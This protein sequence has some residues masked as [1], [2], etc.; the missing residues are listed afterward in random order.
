M[1]DPYETLGI[2]KNAT[3]DEVKAAYRALAKK[4]H[5]DN[6][7]GDPNA[8]ELAE[9]K[10]KVL[11][12][13]YDSIMNMRRAGNANAGAGFNG[14]NAQ[15]GSSQFGTIRSLIAANRLDEA[16]RMLDSVP[17]AQRSAEW[18]FLSG[19][20]QYKRGWFENAYTSFATA[21][22]MDPNNAEYR[23]A[24]NQIQNS[25]GGFNPYRQS[26]TTVGGCSVCDMCTGLICCDQCC[27]CMGGDLIRCC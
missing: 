4:F 6:F 9:E 15:G 21:C 27:E 18:Y 10:M 17:V 20:V 3:D 26:S 7:A 23:A 24:F 8:V 5:P 12:E 22:R 2:S 14:S 16:L 25:R 19:S 11:N 13:A 1:N